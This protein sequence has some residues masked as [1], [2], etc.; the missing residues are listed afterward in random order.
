MRDKRFLPYS[1]FSNDSS[2][3][4]DARNRVRTVVG[5]T[6]SPFVLA[7]KIARNSHYDNVNNEQALLKIQSLGV[8]EMGIRGKGKKIF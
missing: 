7:Q 1:C 8:N 3:A 6:S 4:D 5:G 2:P